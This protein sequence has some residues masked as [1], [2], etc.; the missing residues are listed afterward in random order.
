[1]IW[2]K[3]ININPFAL[4]RERSEGEKM[5]QE[6]HELMREASELRWSA[7]QWRELGQSDIARGRI[8]SAESLE[9]EAA[10]KFRASRRWNR[11]GS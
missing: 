9:L 4:F 6:G 3:I 11:S 10:S 7:Q 8:R 1:M 2:D 5:A